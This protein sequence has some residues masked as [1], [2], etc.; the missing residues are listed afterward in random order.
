MV[1]SGSRTR[2]AFIVSHPV[3]YYVPLYQ[4]LAQ[5]Q[6]VEVKVFYTWHDGEKAVQDSGFGQA[7]AWDIPMREGYAFERVENVSSDPGMHH[8]FGLRNPDLVRRVLE[9]RPDIVHITGWAWW[10][11]LQALRALSKAGVPTLFRGD[12]HLL[13]RQPAGMRGWMKK[14]VLKR[15]YRWPSAFLVTGHANRAYYQAFGVDPAKL[16][17]CP[18]SIDVKRFAEPSANHEQEAARW[19]KD[20]GIEESQTVLLFAGKFEPKK[21][22][23]GFM[24]AIRSRNDDR[25]VGVLV[26]GGE[27][28][29]RVD[30]MARARPHAFRVLPFQN[31]SRMPAV[32]RLGDLFV[33]PSLWGET[34]GLAVNEALASARPVLVSDKVGCAQDVVDESCG[35]VVP[36]D[37]GAWLF[38]A[39]R[40]VPD[41]ATLEKMRTAASLKAQRFDISGTEAAMMDAIPGLVR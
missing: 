28:Q 12:S 34:W 4:R 27:L 9:W 39:I 10:S 8:F 29:D 22:P 40:R 6:D 36:T 32:Y 38:D 35:Y 13:D 15:I 33:L 41:K 23:L 11:H 7:I 16:I 18:H 37:G 5:R 24:E 30:A 25:M 19:R 17:W 31:Q 20:L 14:A 3:Q 1:S 26:G 2:I 21:N